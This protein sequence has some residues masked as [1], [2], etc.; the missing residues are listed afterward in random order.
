MT[1][2]G[3]WSLWKW[4][5]AALFLVSIGF[6]IG[7]G[8]VD[9]VGVEA[10][11][12]EKMIARFEALREVEEPVVSAVGVTD[13]RSVEDLDMAH[14]KLEIMFARLA[15]SVERRTEEERAVFL[16]ALLR[17]DQQHAARYAS[18][19]RDL[20]TVAV[21]T[22]AGFERTEDGLLSLVTHQSPATH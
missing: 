13:E 7:R 20:E 9:V 10:S 6:G 5:A 21:Q 11:L 4:A 18:L 3:G 19:R 15:E 1:A 17:V 22:E 8:T 2:A 14:R 12:E 16:E